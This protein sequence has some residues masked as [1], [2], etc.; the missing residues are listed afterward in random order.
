MVLDSPGYVCA[1]GGDGG[2]GG[3]PLRISRGIEDLCRP[4]LGFKEDARRLKFG[5]VAGRGR[6]QSE[7]LWGRSQEH[8]LQAGLELGR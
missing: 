5:G 4:Q 8:G 2:P 6:P 3:A 1:D 7:P